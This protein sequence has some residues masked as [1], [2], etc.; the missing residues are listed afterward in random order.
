M[1]P[2]DDRRGNLAAESPRNSGFASTLTSTARAVLASF[3]SE[4]GGGRGMALRSRSSSAISRRSASARSSSAARRKASA[5]G[6]SSA[7]VDA[8]GGGGLWC[9]S[10]TKDSPMGVER[11]DLTVWKYARECNSSTRSRA[12]S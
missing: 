3:S 5:D 4:D 9:G 1:I 11:R 10:S 7:G 12:A 6:R 8:G 2:L